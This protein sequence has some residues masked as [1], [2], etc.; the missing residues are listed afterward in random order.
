MQVSVLGVFLCLWASVSN[1][2]SQRVPI[3]TWLSGF[4]DLRASVYL[5]LGQIAVTGES[6]SGR[7][8]VSVCVCLL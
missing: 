1:K 4:V 7:V 2:M 3:S 8:C 5:N 6:K